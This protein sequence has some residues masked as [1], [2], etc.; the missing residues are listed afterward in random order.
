MD[1]GR[2]RR[3]PGRSCARLLEGYTMATA[4]SGGGASEAPCKRGRRLIWSSA[5]ARA[6]PAR[7]KVGSSHQRCR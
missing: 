6:E 7:P 2:G 3:P 1:M 5:P 4:H